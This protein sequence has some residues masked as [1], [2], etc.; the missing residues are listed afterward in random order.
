MQKECKPSYPV[1][2]DFARFIDS[3]GAA[4][5]RVTV[6]LELESTAAN[7]AAVISL[8]LRWKTGNPSRFPQLSSILVLV[9]L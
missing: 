9:C 3:D 2:S 6:D 1:E 5:E 7:L 4:R 8:R